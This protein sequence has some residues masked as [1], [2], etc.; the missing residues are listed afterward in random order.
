MFLFYSLQDKSIIGKLATFVWETVF[1]SAHISLPLFSLTFS[2]RWKVSSNL[3]SKFFS[4]F[5]SALLN[6]SPLTLITVL[7]N[8]VS[9]TISS[10]NGTVVVTYYCEIRGS[11]CYSGT[12]E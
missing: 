7:N 8:P 1:Y 3:R 10:S 12:S 9:M 5:S 6:L 2:L 11:C 4:F